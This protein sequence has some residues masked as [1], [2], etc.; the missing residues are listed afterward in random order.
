MGLVI[1]GPSGA[2]VMCGFCWVECVI[3][4]GVEQGAEDLLIVNG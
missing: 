2:Y 4:Q 1:E 3:G